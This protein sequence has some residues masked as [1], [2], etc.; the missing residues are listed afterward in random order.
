MAIFNQISKNDLK[1]AGFTHKGFI[2]GF[3]P[4]YIDQRDP[5]TLT[6]VV[7]N[8]CPEWI[9][10]L[11]ETMFETT[12]LMTGRVDLTAPLKITGEIKYD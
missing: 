6:I 8:W 7:R 5:S 1:N 12:V 9:F 2:F 10:D 3:V 4:V 11:G